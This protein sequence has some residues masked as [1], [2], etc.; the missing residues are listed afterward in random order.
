MEDLSTFQLSI[1]AV[2]GMPLDHEERPVL[3][4]AR[5]F[6]CG[7]IEEANAAVGHLTRVARMM[8]LVGDGTITGHP[9]RPLCPFLSSISSN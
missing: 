8:R 7:H 4:E 1:E 2:K 5:D 3:E 9:V 6:V